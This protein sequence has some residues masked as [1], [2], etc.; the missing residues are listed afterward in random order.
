MTTISRIIKPYFKHGVYKPRKKNVLKITERFFDKTSE[1]SPSHKKLIISNL[2]FITK[3]EIKNYGLP[4][5]QTEFE[6]F[7]VD[8]Q[9]RMKTMSLTLKLTKAKKANPIVRAMYEKI[10][11]GHYDSKEFLKWP[12][13]KAFFVKNPQLL[14]ETRELLQKILIKLKDQAKNVDEEEI[15]AFE[16]LIGNI[17]SFLTYFDLQDGEKI[18]IP[19]FINKKWVMV[20]YTVEHIRLTPKGMGSPMYAF[21]L[22]PKSRAARPILLFKGTTY[23]ADKGFILSL[24]SDLNIGATPGAYAFQ[25]GRS[26]L[27]AWLKK[28][29]KSHSACVYG[30]SLGGSLAL[31]AVSSMPKYFAKVGAYSPTA[32]LSH[33]KKWK[34]LAKN[35]LAL[36]E[37]NVFCPENDIVPLAGFKWE[38]EWNVYR[39]FSKKKYDFLYAHTQ[40]FFSHKKFLL[41]KIDPKKDQMKPSRIFVS[42]THLICSV[43]LFLVGVQ[44]YCA[45]LLARKVAQCFSLLKQKLI[46]S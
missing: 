15:P 25:L 28:N 23:P 1:Y 17:L 11:T 26:N 36:P 29:T 10:M 6:E 24:L 33:S 5:N 16:S 18:K 37:V 41:L 30:Q 22:V 46:C 7:L 27:K 39:I 21:G 32:L 19:Q 9:S 38:K 40:I 35:P 42:L 12:V 31:Q 2:D 45:Y 14:L 4:K 20:S 3:Q 8:I 13:L 44:F 34:K 43:P